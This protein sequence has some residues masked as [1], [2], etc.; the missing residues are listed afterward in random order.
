MTKVANVRTYVASPGEHVVRVHRPFPLG[1]PFHMRS[2]RDRERVI[3]QF[4]TYFLDRVAHDAAFRAEVLRAEGATLLCFC[5][6]K[7]CHATVIATWLD[8]TRRPR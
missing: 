2:E 3:G 7:P 1:N 4:H 8:S 6:P 5:Y